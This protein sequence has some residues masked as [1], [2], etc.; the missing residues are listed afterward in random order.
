MSSFPYLLEILLHLEQGSDSRAPGGAVTVALCGHW[1]H[2]G[3]CT[4]PHHSSIAPHGENYLLSVAY[5][6]D[7]TERREVEERIRKAVSQ[8]NLIGPDGQHSTWELLD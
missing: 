8:G 6:C 4:W 1:D 3:T 5:Q 7:E 2:D